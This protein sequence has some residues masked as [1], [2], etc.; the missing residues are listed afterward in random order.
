MVDKIFCVCYNY[1]I[2]RVG[3]GKMLTLLSSRKLPYDNYTTDQ[4]AGIF[5]TD[6][7]IY[8]AVLITSIV[9][10]LFLSRKISPKTEKRIRLCIAITI[11]VL[12]IIKIAL[13]IYKQMG[14]E[15]W[16]P[17]YFC[18]IFILA[19]WISLLPCKLIA[20]CGKSYIATG[21]IIGAIFFCIYP[22]TSLVFFPALH[23]ASIH[24]FIYHFLMLYSGIVLLWKGGYKPRAWDGLCYFALVSCVSVPSVILNVRLGTNCM[25]L[26]YPEGIPI[27]KSIADASPVLYTVLALLVQGILLFYIVYGLYTLVLKNK[28]K[29]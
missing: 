28:D 5:T 11:T 19:A 8:L 3:A 18:S 1:L 21:G 17:L 10:S 20:N 6:H 7:F 13:R 24:S 12:E 2:K 23:P 27:L 29:S 4:I 26:R 22:N 9:V 15:T 14:L 16:L 25:F